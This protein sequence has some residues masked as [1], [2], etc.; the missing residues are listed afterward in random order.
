VSVERIPVQLFDGLLVVSVQT[1]LHDRLAVTLQQ[2]LTLRLSEEDN[3]GCLLDISAVKVVDTYVSRIFAEMG[4]TARLLGKELVLVGMRPSVAITL[5][6]LGVELVG[7][8][9]AMSLDEGKAMILA[10]R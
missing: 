3:R 1:E 10:G 2:D 9:A 8:R 4:A 6:D 5:V 7:L